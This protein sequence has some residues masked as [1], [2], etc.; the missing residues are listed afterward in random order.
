MN[1][2]KNR[3]SNTGMIGYFSDL[4]DDQK[5]LVR[6]LVESTIDQVAGWKYGEDLF[7]EIECV[8][9]SGFFAFDSNR[10]GLRAR[11]F[12]DVY[13][14]E[15]SGTS[16]SHEGAQKEIKRQIAYAYECAREAFFKVNSAKLIALGIKS[17]TDEKLNYHDLYEMKQ[18]T[19]AEE[20]SEYERENM[21]GDDS[22]IMFETRF[23]YHGADE[24][25]LHSAS[26]SCAVNTEGP[27]HRSHIP[28]SPG[29]FC[30][31]A[32]EIEITW[33]TTAGLKKSLAKALKQTSEV[34]F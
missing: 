10:G 7:E 29:V 14:L 8:S 27:Y 1:T 19:L 4:S 22:S 15:G 5:E 13:G 30:E 2:A 20:L 31:G 16:V 6:E 3:F 24:N 11:Q 32:K 25:G 26:V 9:R 17:V 28:W 23:L 21:S 18:G 34:I 12:T 33:K